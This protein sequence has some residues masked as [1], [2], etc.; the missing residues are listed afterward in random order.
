MAEANAGA[1]GE[2][3]ARFLTYFNRER[4]VLIVGGDSGPLVRELE[5]H[6]L[7]S[8]IAHDAF[9]MKRLRDGLSALALYM[10]S[11]PGFETSGWT[12]SLQEPPL[13]LFFTGSARDQTVVGRAFLEGVEPS[14]KNLFYAETSREFG[15]RQRS[16]V[17]VEG[18]D[19]FGIVEQYCARS[20]QQLAR[21]F[22][23][24]EGDVALLS[25]LPGADQ[26]WL[27]EVGGDEIFSLIRAGGLKLISDRRVSFLCGCDT[28][29]ITK[30]VVDLYRD[31]P[32]DLF[33]GD[34][35]VE[36]ECPRCGAKH[37]V[38]RQG[39]ERFLAA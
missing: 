27:Q 5:L 39:F 8:D 24:G 4:D 30:I 34:P 29:R 38:S 36:A 35:A 17:D 3:K 21:F 12:I 18:S 25:S 7:A 14:R 16:S 22:S 23:Y 9:T 20:D 28:D 15:D 11:R 1:V 13:N 26:E 6:L 32:E 37:S 19:I 2:E 31:D 10:M 33:R